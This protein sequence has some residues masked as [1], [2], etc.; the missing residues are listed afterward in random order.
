MADSRGS[1]NGVNV[2]ELQLIMSRI[3]TLTPQPQFII[4]PGDMING[5]TN[6]YSTISSQLQTWKNT[7][8]AYKPASVFFLELEITKRMMALLMPPKP[9]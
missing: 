9:Q 3:T 4:F 7:V 5:G 1:T 8:T 6:T 2:P